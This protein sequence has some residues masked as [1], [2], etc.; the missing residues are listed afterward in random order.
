MVSAILPQKMGW[1]KK[2]A[3]LTSSFCF[4]KFYKMF[5]SSNHLGLKYHKDGI[6]KKFS[7]LK[8]NNIFSLETQNNMLYWQL[9]LF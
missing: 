7:F 5:F 1:V 2:S 4:M 8:K 6:R 3:E 9:P